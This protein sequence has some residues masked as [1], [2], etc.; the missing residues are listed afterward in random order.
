MIDTIIFDLGGV[1]VDF[2]PIEGM[3]KIGFSEKAVEEFENKIFSGLWEECDKYQYSDSQ[4]RQLFKERVPG[5]E[6]EVD[7]LWNNLHSITGTRD[8][9]NEWLEDLKARGYRLLVLSNFGKNSF[10]INSKIYDFL[11]YMDGGIISYELGLVKPDDKIYKAL[12]EKY[13]IVPERAVFIDDREENVQA[14][15]ALGIKGIV[16]ENYEQAR[17]EL[18]RVCG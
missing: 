17:R 7:M 14:A 16:F 12:M 3:R 18:A 13:N 4:I 1:L 8:Y 10:E 6:K 5:F 9:S 2:H 15:R 11:K